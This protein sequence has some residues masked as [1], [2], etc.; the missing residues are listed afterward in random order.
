M[1]HPD[2]KGGFPDSVWTIHGHVWQEEPYVDSCDNPEDCPQ[3]TAS[4]RLGFNP[5]SQWMGSRDGFGPGNQFDILLNK[6]GGSFSVPGDYLY[7]SYPANGEFINGAWGVFR[8]LPPGQ[9]TFACPQISTVSAA[10]SLRAPRLVAP[11][12]PPGVT[13]RPT[14][15][16]FE[17]FFPPEDQPKPAPKKKTSKRK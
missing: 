6:A 1:L 5:L 11:S 10:A 3:F 4:S 9:K 13:P 16:G 7:R 8:V 15:N 14:K 12:V 17:R 2:G